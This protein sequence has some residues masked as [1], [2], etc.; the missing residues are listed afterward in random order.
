[1]TPLP[2]PRRLLIRGVNWL[3]DAIMTTPAL[4]R[5]RQ[6]L[7]DTEITLLAH[8]KLADLWKHHPSINEALTFAPDES[9]LS[10][11]GRIR[12]GGFDAALIL[13]NSPRSALESWLAGVPQ[14]VGYARPW[15]NFC[16]THKVAE[17]PGEVRMAKRSPDEIRSLIHDE[18]VV[19]RKQIPVSAHQS[20]EYLYL[21]AT[22]GARAE[23]IPPLIAVQ[24]EEIKAASDRFGLASTGETSKPL[25]G[26][27]AGAEYGPA[28]RWPIDRFISAAAEIQKR[29]GCHWLIFGGPKDES[30]GAEVTA[31]ILNALPKPAAGAGSTVLNLAGKTTL[32]ELCALLKLCRVLL[33]NDSG[34]MHLAAA[35]GTPAVVP[36]GSTSPE[37]TGPGLPSTGDSHQIL[38]ANA[39]CSP[40]FLRVCP[41]DLRCMTGISEGQV[42]DAVLKVA[43]SRGQTDQN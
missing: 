23:P 36:F 27:N 14:R 16:L 31:G 8:D 28:K 13:P 9:V 10:V 34:P 39:P 42:V 33:T 19:D 7:P 4:Q 38:Q 35:V 22:F 15:R 12:A 3:G 21:G 24:S 30:L 5:L 6:A 32:R 37:L 26:L 43:L 29:I 17:R 41:I 18:A 40:C 11:A 25:F 2:P 1:V 20:N